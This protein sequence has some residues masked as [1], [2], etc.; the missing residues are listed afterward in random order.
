MKIAEITYKYLNSI[1]AGGN[2]EFMEMY[3]KEID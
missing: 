3:I 1:N 2:E